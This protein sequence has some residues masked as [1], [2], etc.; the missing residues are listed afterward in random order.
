MIDR[1]LAS[2]RS[3]ILIF[4]CWFLIHIDPDVSYRGP[5]TDLTNVTLDEK[6]PH[7][8]RPKRRSWDEM[9]RDEKSWDELEKTWEE[10][11][12]ADWEFRQIQKGWEE[13]RWA[14]KRWEEIKRDEKQQ[15]SLD[16]QEVPCVPRKAQRRCPQRPAAQRSR[17]TKT[18]ATAAQRRGGILSLQQ[19]RCQTFL[20]ES[21][22]APAE[23][24]PGLF[25][26][27]IPYVA[28]ATRALPKLA[29]Q[30]K[31]KRVQ[32]ISCLLISP[33]LIWTLL[34]CYQIWTLLI[35]FQLMGGLLNF[36]QLISATA[37][38]DVVTTGARQRRSH[39]PLIWSAWSSAACTEPAYLVRSSIC[40]PAYESNLQN[41]SI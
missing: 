11:R 24:G 26:V 33:H 38:R 16:R 3:L 12:W 39:A 8:G 40:L 10:L 5:N 37:Q 14:E 13:L 22:P 15:A 20:F 27:V 41:L 6:I 19:S 28:H 25:S 34:T 29:Q 17:G 23:H 21:L 30:M 4:T 35:Y 2:D 9:R 7:Y 32:L 18:T 36:A 1:W 31:Y